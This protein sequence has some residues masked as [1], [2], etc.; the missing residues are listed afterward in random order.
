MY[1]CGKNGRE[2]PVS[3]RASA[4]AI[5]LRSSAAPS[6]LPPAVKFP[7]KVVAGKKKKP[8]CHKHYDITSHEDILSYTCESRLRGLFQLPVMCLGLSSLPSYPPGPFSCIALPPK[9]CQFPSSNVSS[10]SDVKLLLCPPHG[11]I[12]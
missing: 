12:F 11:R 10:E 9:P 5:P 3:C 1:I 2:T 4:H 7:G 6:D 8:F